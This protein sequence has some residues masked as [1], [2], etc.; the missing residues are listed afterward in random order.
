MKEGSLLIVSS[1]QTMEIVSS[2]QKMEGGERTIMHQH[3]ETFSRFMFLTEDY[4]TL[5][6]L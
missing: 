6:K 4:L 1:G 2:S 5:E 3:E